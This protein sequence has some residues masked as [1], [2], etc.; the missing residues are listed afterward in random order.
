MRVHA[1]TIPAGELRQINDVGL[2]ARIQSLTGGSSVTISTDQGVIVPISQGQKIRF[3]QPY[4]RLIIT[5]PGATA[6]TLSILVG[7]G[8]FDDAAIAGTV[9]I[10]D[11]NP[12]NVEFVTPQQTLIERVPLGAAHYY[13]M[14]ITTSV[15]TILTP[16]SNINGVEITRGLL[17][18]YNG[19]LRLSCASAVPASIDDAGVES[20]LDVDATSSNYNNVVLPY[21]VLIPA[22]LGL[23]HQSNSTGTQRI[24]LSYK[25][26]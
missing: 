18:V 7:D 2:F 8:D 20:V 10:D 19:V 12:V 3:P 24:S 15:V 9:S 6:I 5:N 21:P 22:G 23:Y 17:A 25:V 14:N 16:A 1:I 11:T 26:L 4:D 13:K